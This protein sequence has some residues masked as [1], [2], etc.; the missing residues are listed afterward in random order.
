MLL[1]GK[2]TLDSHCGLPKDAQRSRERQNDTGRLQSLRVTVLPVSCGFLWHR[3]KI[4]VGLLPGPAHRPQGKSE[5]SGKYVSCCL[6]GSYR[7]NSEGPTL[8]PRLPLAC[9]ERR[10]ATISVWP[11][12][13][14]RCSGV[15][16]CT[17]S[18][19]ADPPYCSRLR[20]TS[21]W[22]CLAAMCK[23]V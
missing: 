11:S 18:A 13:A 14:A 19:F 6:H 8:F 22:F 7:A 3:D 10:R 12:W 2:Y 23:G 16:P 9:F 17:D 20:A 4:D 1:R 15:T 21:I 5:C